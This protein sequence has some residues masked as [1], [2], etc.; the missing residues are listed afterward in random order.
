RRRLHVHTGRAM[1]G[2]DRVPQRAFVQFHMDHVLAR[3]LHRFLNRDWHFTR[4][5]VA[6]ANASITITDHGQCGKR[7][8]ATALDGLGHAVHGDQLLKEAVG[9]LTFITRHVSPFLP[10][11]SRRTNLA[12]EAAWS[13]MEPDA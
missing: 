10:L 8:L 5:A 12:A 6:K 13:C 7:H 3:T 2:L 4:L 1:V 11:R 9:A